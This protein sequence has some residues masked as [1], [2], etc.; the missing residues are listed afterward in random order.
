MEAF[1]ASPSIEKARS[2]RRAT[3]GS[4]SLRR[5]RAG[6]VSIASASE[7]LGSAGTSLAIAS[8][9]LYGIPNTRPTSRIT[10]LAFIRPKVMIWAT[11]S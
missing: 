10:A 6:S 9:S 2:I 7:I 1:R 8:T 5:L 11:F 4:F 3:L